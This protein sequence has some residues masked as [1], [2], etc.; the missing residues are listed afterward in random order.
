MPWS[1]WRVYRSKTGI[2]LLCWSRPCVFLT[3]NIIFYCFLSDEVAK[4]YPRDSPKGN[5]IIFKK[6]LD[7]PDNT[8]LTVIMRICIKR[9][10]RQVVTFR[11]MCTLKVDALAACHNQSLTPLL[12]HFNDWFLS[13]ICP[14]K[15]KHN[16]W[17]LCARLRTLPFAIKVRDKLVYCL[18]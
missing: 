3:C 9:V 15:W 6:C 12:S 14:F 4:T 5:K 7:K 16:F 10:V 2:F 17:D 8:F 18:D 13:S 11:G 1:N